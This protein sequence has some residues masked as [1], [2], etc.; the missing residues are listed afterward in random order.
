MK[1][2]VCGNELTEDGKCMTCRYYWK[3]IGLVIGGYYWA[4]LTVTAPWLTVVGLLLI[5]L[6]L[7][8]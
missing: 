2:D 5:V 6:I 7:A 4:I 3:V 1:C 8:M